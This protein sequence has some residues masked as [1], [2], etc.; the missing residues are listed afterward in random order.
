MSD[1]HPILL[2]DDDE[3]DRYI[4]QE[5]FVHAGC[6]KDFLQFESGT[7]LISHLEE[8]SAD[9]YPCL[10]LLDLNMPIID[11]RE[12]LKTIKSNP[13][14]SHIPVIVF[15]TSRLDKDRRIS[16]ELGANCFISKPSGYQ[17]VLDITRSIATL[18]C[19]ASK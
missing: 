2:V 16:Y 15:T 19:L 11:G 5:G 3:D 4:F 6:K 17:D 14:W 1:K 12:V 18:W 9:E 10:I 7:S 13:K 8:A